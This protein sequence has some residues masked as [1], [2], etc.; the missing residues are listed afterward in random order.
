MPK[1][2]IF[3]NAL[4]LAVLLFSLFIAGNLIPAAAPLRV[5]ISDVGSILFNLFA[6]YMLILAAAAARHRSRNLF[7]TWTMW[8]LAQLAYML[9]DFGWAFLELGLHQSPYPSVADIFYL[10]Y[11]P[12]VLA[13]ILLLPQARLTR[14]EWTKKILDYAVILVAALL[15]FGNFIIGPQTAS[16]VNQPWAAKFLA[17]AYPSGDLLLLWGLVMLIFHSNPHENAAPLVWLGNGL[18]MMIIADGVFSIQT[19]GG[20]YVSGG[21]ADLCWLAGYLLI[22]LA[23][24][25][26]VSLLQPGLPVLAETS[27]RMPGLQIRKALST[28][29]PYLWLVGAFALLVYGDFVPLPMGFTT[30]LLGVGLVIGL[31]L[32]RQWITLTENHRLVNQLNAALEQVR[33][34]AASQVSLNIDLQGEIAERK[35]V[36]RELAYQ[37]LHDS[38][39]GLPN[40]ILF[41]DRLDHLIA[42]SSRY[43]GLSFAILFLDLDY[44]KVVNDSLGH[45]T[46]DQLLVMVGQRL[47]DCLRPNDTVSRLGG[48]EFVILLE[49]IADEAAA[50]LVAER[51]QESLSMPLKIQGYDVFTSASI[52]IVIYGQ[53]YAASEEM[54]RDA[55]VAMYHAKALGKA[56]YAVFSP[57]MRQKAVTR[58][59]LESELRRAFEEQEFRLYYQPIYNLA[60]GEVSGFEALLRW[61]HPVRGLLLPGAFLQVAEESGLI[62]PLGG[63]VLQQACLQMSRWR[64]VE[65][66]ASRLSINVNIASKQFAQ[67]DFVEQ[68]ISALQDSGLPPEALKLEIT[69]G[70]MI[71]NSARAG[72]FFERLTTLGVNLEV[73][74]FGTGYSSLSYLQ[75][76]P[77][78]TIKI[79]RSFI[80]EIGQPGKNAELVRTILLMA[81]DLGMDAIAEGIETEAQLQHLQKLNCPMGQGFLFSHALEASRAE[82][83]ICQSA[84]APG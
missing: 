22:G 76:F 30:V 15:V 82:E 37:A 31:V 74:D 7:L 50:S 54:L 70:V 55:D 78:K 3:R 14:S 83:L 35:R 64:A 67:I 4:I 33:L 19:L 53:P 75:H 77:I 29:L 57:D 69:E 27:R 2:S 49:D 41:L 24:A 18:M 36:E 51:L 44:F 16:A 79:D 11:Y 38:L 60:T 42:Q 20:S 6:L 40:R 8:A 45:S 72:D 47:S 46:G 81:K 21:L 25:K 5:A 1:T 17:V 71:D 73:D 48:D 34:Q 23:G 65:P 63:W 61:Q 12:L 80:Q 39:T 66:F 68:V 43:P 32:V 10:A 58:L 52:G 84:A 28:L 56:R 62:L 26:Q 59:G 9:G 13:G